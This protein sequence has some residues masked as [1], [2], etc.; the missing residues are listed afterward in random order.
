MNLF[1]SLDFRTIHFQG[2]NA[3]DAF[4]DQLIKALILWSKPLFQRTNWLTITHALLPS[5]PSWFTSASRYHK[6]VVRP[7]KIVTNTTKTLCQ[8]VS[9]SFGKNR[10][11]KSS[12]YLKIFIIN[13]KTYTFQKLLGLST[14][15]NST[16]Y[17]LLTRYPYNYVHYCS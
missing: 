17:P 13:Q 12:M 16:L 11:A 10:F 6:N 4:A 7:I 14:G 5:W 3:L 8:F 15:L 9:P 2:I 1:R